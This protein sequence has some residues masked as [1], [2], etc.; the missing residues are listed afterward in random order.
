MILCHPT[1][2]GEFSG[3]PVCLSIFGFKKNWRTSFE[4][5]M[6]IAFLW[7]KFYAVHYKTIG[8]ATLVSSFSTVLFREKWFYRVQSLYRTK[9]FKICHK[10]TKL[11]LSFLPVKQQPVFFSTILPVVHNFALVLSFRSS[12]T[13]EAFVFFVICTAA[14]FL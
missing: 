4:C 11:F 1:R 3:S 13:T 14:H 10:E 5:E 8:D 9:Y 6:L 7:D 12:N 2:F